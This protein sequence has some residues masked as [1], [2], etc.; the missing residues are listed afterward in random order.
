MGNRWRW[1]L[2]VALYLML[3]TTACGTV[4]VTPTPGRATPASSATQ[5]PLPTIP[6]T[7]TGTATLGTPSAAASGIVS[8]PQAF[9]TLP[10]V[11]DGIVNTVM[12][13]VVDA[14]S[15]RTWIFDLAFADE[16]HGWMIAAD[17]Q[18]YGKGEPLPRRIL[19][20]ADG[21]KT[22]N[23]QLV[24]P[25][26][27][28]LD[29]VSATQ[30]WAIRN[31]KPISS[32]DGGQH[33]QETWPGSLPEPIGWID[34]TDAAHGWADGQRLYTP[35]D[36]DQHLYRTDDGGQHWERIAGADPCRQRRGDARYSFI[37]P[38]VGWMLCS[39]GA[40]M[41]STQKAVFKTDDGAQSWTL[42]TE[43]TR[44]RQ[45]PG[46]LDISSGSLAFFFIN[47]TDGWFSGQRGTVMTTDGGRTW[48]QIGLPPR[49]DLPPS[50]FVRFISRQQGFAVVSGTSTTIMKTVD[51]GAHWQPIFATALWPTGAIRFLDRRT[52]I[53]AGTPL[54]GGAILRSTDGGASW[55]PI[56]SIGTP[57]SRVKQ[58]SFTDASNGWANTYTAES[59]QPCAFYR[60]ADGGV[61]WRQLPRP[62]ADLPCDERGSSLQFIDRQ[63]GFLAYGGPQGSR[64]LITSDG[65]ASFRP[66][67]SFPFWLKQIAFIDANTGW[68]ISGEGIGVDMVVA[69]TDGG[70]TWRALP[71]NY[72]IPWTPSVYQGVQNGTPVNPILPNYGAIAPNLFPGGQAWL[73]VGVFDPMQSTNL[74]LSTGDDGKT[75]TRFQLAG[76]QVS[77]KLAESYSG[78]PQFVDPAHGWLI[79]G[80]QLL[81]T[82]D[83]GRT[84]VQLR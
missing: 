7:P 3:I 31:G 20:T 38:Q 24:A 61:T 36:R 15:P 16:R 33:W 40:A 66:I 21:G 37:G 52:G 74:L 62:A 76:K 18:P 82:E 1:R 49:T 5:S 60:T 41:G 6:P 75:W 68:A 83:G 46:G 45:T 35:E 2:L 70:H 78:A 27:Q 63:T 47:P 42:L 53:A 12:A 57:G 13:S 43:T 79:N 73:M 72:R 58:F 11:T 32:T 55:E 77:G 26:L 48:Q 9:P 67:A 17:L 25:D 80:D 34:F 71:R 30:V 59:P 19:A 22:W 8:S 64:L 50:V 39:Y 29:A 69:T 14:S 84:W 56:G 4:G 65:G 10:P 51:G 28:G 44:D 23:E 54:D 81:R